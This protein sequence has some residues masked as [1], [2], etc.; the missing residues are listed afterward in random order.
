MAAH[1]RKTPSSKATVPS[2]GYHRVRKG[3]SLW[4]LANRFGTT[5]E[6]IK[7][8]NQ[9]R[10]NNLV[11]GQTLKIPGFKTEP[12]PDAD[13]L[14]TYSV[15]NGDSPYTIAMQHNMELDRLLTINK[16]TPRSKIYPGQK[17]F[18]E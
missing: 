1:H 4:N 13:Q 2:T 5:V 6:Q 3:D 7:S 15:K 8:L 10:S 14:S 9:L 16:L 18:I 12:L 17:L 11:I